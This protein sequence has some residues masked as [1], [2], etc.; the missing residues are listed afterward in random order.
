MSWVRVILADRVFA[1]GVLVVLALSAL[2]AAHAV[3]WWFRPE[4]DRGEEPGW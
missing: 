1:V 2:V 3:R 4:P